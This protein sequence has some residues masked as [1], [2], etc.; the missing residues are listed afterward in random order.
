MTSRGTEFK[1]PCPNCG[2]RS[3]ITI[4]SRLAGNGARVRRNSC[5]DC[6]ERFTTS[7]DYNPFRAQLK[8][9]SDVADKLA[10]LLSDCIKR[11]LSVYEYGEAEVAIAA[12]TTFQSRP[13]GSLGPN[14]RPLSIPAVPLRLGNGTPYP[15]P[16]KNQEH[17]MRSLPD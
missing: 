14:P 6:G 12:W 2:G 3:Q 17:L 5:K 10:S 1:Y 15:Q 11:G 9:L 4:D 16:K 7:G 13:N 8:E